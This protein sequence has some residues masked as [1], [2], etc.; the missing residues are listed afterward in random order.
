MNQPPPLARRLSVMKPSATVAI[1]QRATE[2]KAQGVDVLSFSLGEPDFETPENI[3]AAARRAVDRGSSHYTSVRGVPELLEAICADSARRR[4]G[5]AHTPDEVVVS[6]GAKHSLFNL[7]MALFEPGDEVVVPA[8]HWVSYPAQ[9]ELAGATPVSV[10][11]TAEEGFRLSP[12]ALRGALSERTKA[13]ILC[14][15]NN[16]TGS[17]YAP[18][19]LRALADVL[20]SHS[21]WIVVDEIYA[22]LTYDGFEQRSLLEVAPEL[23]DRLVIVD[24]CSKTYAMTGWRIGW[25]LAPAHVAKACEKLQG[26]ATTNPAAVAQ[27]AAIEALSGP[28]HTVETMRAAFAE[29][30]QIIVSGLDAIDGIRCRMPEG[31]FYAFCDVSA[32]IGRRAKGVVLED[33]VA[34]STYLLEEARCAVVPGS[35]FGAP[36]H[37]RMSYAASPEQI[38]EGVRRIAAAVAALE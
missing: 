9:V 19:Q 15:P 28:Q 8:P 17:A 34:V 37:L 38:R 16:P 6:V 20:A 21:C 22:H 13:L 29:R 12:S 26:Q 25:I 4:G 7:A 27:Y 14:S 23:R 24:G 10:P 11:S 18:D 2:L 35:A 5:H 33:D 1:S 32:L 31:A 3:R 30:R 36:G